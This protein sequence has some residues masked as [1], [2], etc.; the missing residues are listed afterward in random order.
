MKCFEYWRY[1]AIHCIVHDDTVGLHHDQS[2]LSFDNLSL[3]LPFALMAPDWVTSVTEERLFTGNSTHM[4]QIMHYQKV[5]GGSGTMCS[6]W[7][8]WWC[9][10]CYKITD[11]TLEGQS[12]HIWANYDDFYITE[13]QLS[14]QWF[15]FI[16]ISV[17]KLDVNMTGSVTVVFKIFNIN[18]KTFGAFIKEIVNAFGKF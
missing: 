12:D 6:A 11:R 8:N 16:C 18:S 4:I 5:C 15:S 2:C 3:P 1:C 10:C 13:D 17:T 9:H 7:W 14:S